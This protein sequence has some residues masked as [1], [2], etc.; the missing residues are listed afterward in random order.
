MHRRQFL[1]AAGLAAG[2]ARCVG[3]VAATGRDGSLG[4]EPYAPLGVVDVAGAREAVVGS[5]GTTAYVAASDGFAIVDVSD[6]TDPQVLAERRRL[7]A[8]REGGPLRGVHDVAVSGDR[9]LVVGPAHPRPDA[10]SGAALYDVTDPAAPRLLRFHPT[11]YPIHNADLA[12]GVAYLTA[13]GADGNALAVVNPGEGVELARW[14]VAD[15][16]PEWE[17]VPLPLRVVHDVTVRDGRAHV[18][19]WDAGTWILNVDDPAAPHP[20]AEDVAQTAGALAGEDVDVSAESLQLPGN[21]HYAASTPETGA[22]GLVGVGRE[23]WDAAP[24]DGRAG[25]PGGVDLYDRSLTPLASVSPP[26]TPDPGYDGVWTTAHNF[27]F[28]RGRLYSA[29]YQG[30]VRIH[31]LSDP[32]DPLEL[33]WWRDPEWAFWTAVPASGCAVAAAF[34]RGERGRGRLYTF[35]DRPGEQADPPPLTTTATNASGG[36]T[37]PTTATETEPTTPSGTTTTTT[38]ETTTATTGATATP[39]APGF[40]LLAG[41]AGLAGG[42]LVRRHRNRRGRE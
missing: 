1:R 42:A 21:S 36:G 33:A 4:A 32:A 2:T 20:V 12:G 37:A 15:A 41:L 27:G 11:D 25:G 30:G 14:S 24:D 34:R 13:N 38:D 18:A 3:P 35:P 16:A 26:A 17:A 8:D 23:A 40:G 19:H 10:L 31:D 28:G 7:L 6:P 9:L 29:W 22:A 39:G 5:A